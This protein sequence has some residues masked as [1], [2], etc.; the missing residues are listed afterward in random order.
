MRPEDISYITELDELYAKELKAIKNTCE[1]KV[2]LKKWD[3]WLDESTKKLKNW[4]RIKSLI[5]DCRKENAEFEKKH[6]PIALLLLPERI[7]K[8]SI[9]ACQFSAPWGCAYIRM[10]EEGQ[11]DY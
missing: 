1:F 11:I 6:E 5:A 10:R 3:Y 9:I 8:I 4:E 2:F 7:F